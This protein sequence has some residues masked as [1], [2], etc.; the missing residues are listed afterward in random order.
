M[1]IEI[2]KS[3]SDLT[4]KKTLSFPEKNIV[5]PTM[6]YLWTTTD[7]RNSALSTLAPVSVALVGASAIHGDKN[8]QSFFK[9]FHPPSWAIRDVRLYTALDVA[10]IAP[11]GYASY[12]VYKNG[13][14]FDYS[15]TTAALGIYGLN[16]V[17]GLALIPAFKKKN[18]KWI[19]INA[20]IVA[21]TAIAA[22]G[23]FG[24][25]DKMAG[26]LIAPYALWTTYYANCCSKRPSS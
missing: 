25:I 19:A 7:S 6:P 26:Y 10:T 13:G 5:P 23:A 2:H 22:S 12:L 8:L 21:A 1:D 20:G 17:S 3:I 14:G 18:L 9:S 4:G 24:K 16:L 11:L 15:D